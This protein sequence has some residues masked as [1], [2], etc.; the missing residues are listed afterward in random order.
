M[1]FEEVTNKTIELA[2]V[3][4]L[5]HFMD[6]LHRRKT[7]YHFNSSLFCLTVLVISNEVP[8]GVGRECG[9]ACS[10]QTEKQ[11]SVSIF[12]LVSRAVH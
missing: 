8:G 10:R 3:M 6:Q 2:S 7:R 9:L 12:A 1:G 11:G 5:S 4:T